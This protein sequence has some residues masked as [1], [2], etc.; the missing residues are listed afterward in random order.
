M[1]KKKKKVKIY[2]FPFSTFAHPVEVWIPN[3][4]SK[5]EENMRQKSETTVLFS[6]HVP[7][8]YSGP[9]EKHRPPGCLLAELFSGMTT[10][11]EGVPYRNVFLG[12]PRAPTKKSWL[13]GSGYQCQ[14]WYPDKPRFGATP[15]DWS[16]VVPDLRCTNNALMRIV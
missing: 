16:S 3:M 10:C 5:L 4:F 11:L 6:C 9:T 2:F 12:R 13:S 14:D 8:D 7:N 15:A 1:I